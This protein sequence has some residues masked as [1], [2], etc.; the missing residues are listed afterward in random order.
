[1]LASQPQMILLKW[2]PFQNIQQLIKKRKM[3]IFSR[4]K[5][6]LSAA[7]STAA[8]LLLNMNAKISITK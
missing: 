1:M 5:I 2:G 4:Q 8:P 6:P 3:Q 7:A